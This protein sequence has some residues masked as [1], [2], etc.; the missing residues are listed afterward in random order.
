MRK[1]RRVAWVFASIGLLILSC[2]T[3]ESI[4]PTPID[5]ELGGGFEGEIVSAN[6]LV[7]RAKDG[8][9]LLDGL[10]PATVSADA[11]PL[12]GFAVRDE[13]TTYEMQFGSFKPTTVANGPWRVA[14]ALERDGASISLKEN[15]SEIARVGL[16]TPEEGHLVFELFPVDEPDPATPERRMRL[17]MGFAC[18]ANDHFIGL[19]S[20]TWDVDHRGQTVPM[21][22][23]EQGVGK[24]M[25]DDYGNLWGLEGQRHS[26]HAPIPEFLS[27]RGYIFVAETDR[28][29]LVALCSERETAARIEVDLPAK[30]HLFDG[31]K[32]VQAIERATGTFG[33]PRMPPLVSFAPWLDAIFG[34]ENVRRV[35]EKLRSEGIPGS[36]IW[37]EDWRGGDLKGDDYSLKEEWEVDRTLYPDFEALADDLHD[38]GFDFHVYFNPFVYE[39]SKAWSETAPNGFLVKQADGEP[40]TFQ[41]AKFTATGLIDLTNPD[42]R[43]WAIGKMQA[44]IELGA[45]GWMN[46]FAEW[47][48]MDGVVASGPSYEVHNVYPVLWQEVAREAIDTAFDGRDRLFFARSGWFG[49]PE[50]VDVFWAGDQRTSFDVDDGLPTIIPM[51]HRHIHLWPRHRW[52]SIGDQSAFHQRAF[53]PLDVTRRLVARHAHA[54]RDKAKPRMEL[55]KGRRDH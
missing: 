10:P 47:L 25:T 46:D 5:L 39:G 34:S 31:P 52:L 1:L 45:D 11:P 37:T 20:Q 6:R 42:A 2:S 8:R 18:D 38:L 17:S 7:I 44:A 51:G 33:R 54:P 35:A 29:A 13:T 15:G 23:S 49:T 22:V 48:P 26:S 19:G 24:S 16:T 4:V 12:V 36:V 40:Y 30:F 53:L 32:P 43:D 28:R 27:K 14:T 50:L 9:V 55:G 21:F 41:G 3:D